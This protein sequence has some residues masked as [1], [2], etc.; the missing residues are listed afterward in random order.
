MREVSFFI[1][2]EEPGNVLISRTLGEQL[3]QTFIFKARSFLRRN[4]TGNQS[5]VSK[6]F[7]PDQCYLEFH[8]IGGEGAGLISKDI[9][10]LTKF[11]IERGGT[12]AWSLLT[13]VTVHEF[14]VIYEVRLRHLDDFD[15]DDQ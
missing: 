7:V 13:I 11:L 10:N 2:G 8:T 15:G 4:I 1:L 3:L 14:I 12:D 9:L 6:K 5:N